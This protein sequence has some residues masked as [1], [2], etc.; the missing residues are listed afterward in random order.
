MKKSD[1]IQVLFK[2]V[3]YECYDNVVKNQYVYENDVEKLE[4]LF[5]LCTNGMQFHS[6]RFDSLYSLINTMLHA[7]ENSSKVAY[8]KSKLAFI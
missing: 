3:H 5:E 8:D 6:D 2:S 4:A 1:A 7:Y